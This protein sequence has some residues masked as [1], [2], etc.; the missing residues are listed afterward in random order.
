MCPAVSSTVVDSMSALRSAC[1]GALLL[2]GCAPRV[3]APQPAPPP[4]QPPAERQY[5]VSEAMLE[6]GAIVVHVEIPPKPSGRKPA[7]LANLNESSAL[8]DEGVI[9]VTYTIDWTKLP[10]APP[11][12]TPADKVGAGK[13]ALTAPTPQLVGEQFLR[14]IVATATLVV[15]KVIDFL[16]TLPEVD[17]AR[18]A[19]TGA[20]TNGFI[21]LQAIS[22]EPRLS[23]AVAIAACGDFFRFLRYSSMGMEGRPLDLDPDYASWLRAQQPIAHPQRLVHAALL[24]VNRTQDPIIPIACADE[25]ERVLAPVYA[26]SGVS[27][28]FRYVRVTDAAGHGLAPR[29][30]AENRAWLRQWLLGKR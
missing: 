9:A 8:L 15:P 18:L 23:V 12:P 4:A 3:P 2:V 22:T 6:N 10:G 25:T 26:R 20:S 7:V 1:W 21:A 16:L 14:T 24:M 11:P 30:D 27:R 17:P 13:W 28:R 29:E 19:I 5:S